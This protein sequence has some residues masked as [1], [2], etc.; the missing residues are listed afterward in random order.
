MWWRW[1][2][3]IEKARFCLFFPPDDA[4]YE[5]P[6]KGR[7]SAHNPIPKHN[8]YDRVCILMEFISTIPKERLTIY[9]E[10]LV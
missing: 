1:I 9:S 5:V 7:K 4:E 8:L 10:R 2:V 3:Q 6:E